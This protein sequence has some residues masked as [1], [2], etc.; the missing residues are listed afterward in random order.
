MSKEE[1]VNLLVKSGY[2]AVLGDDG[3]VMVVTDNYP[4]LCPKIARIAAKSGYRQS[5]GVKP[6]RHDREK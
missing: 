6:E 1:F 2:K 3:V 5:W 4:A